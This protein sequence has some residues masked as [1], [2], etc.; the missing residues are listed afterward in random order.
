MSIRAIAGWLLLIA[1]LIS[2]WSVWTHRSKDD[3]NTASGQSSYIL[4]DFELTSLDKEGKEAFTLRA[5]LLQETPGA[6]TM[7]LT[8]PVFFIPDR[9]DSRQYWEVKANTGWVS[10]KRDE[11]RLVGAVDARS[12]AAA[13]SQTQLQTERMNLFPET[14]T[15]TSDAVV[16]VTQPG[17]TMTG[18]GM[19][20]DLASKQVKLESEVKAQYV[21][22]RR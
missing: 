19:R 6:Q 15:A 13:A 7:D 1:V 11:V 18:R 20:A 14:N 12:P 2:G 5:P 16:K 22:N 17:L 10:E 8:S 3:D 9:A 4:R 21:P